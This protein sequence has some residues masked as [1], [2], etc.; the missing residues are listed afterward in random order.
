M[1]NIFNCI[2]CVTQ[3]EYKAKSADL[4]KK[5][6]ELSKKPVLKTQNFS[7]NWHDLY[8][9]LDEEKQ[10]AFWHGLLSEIVV[11]VAG[12]VVRLLY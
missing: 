12:Q 11:D 5:I 1:F 4:Q 9:E 7:A 6:A 3:A 2:F 8:H 10:R